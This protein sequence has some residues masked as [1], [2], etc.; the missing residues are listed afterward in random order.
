MSF[1]SVPRSARLFRP[2]A[3]ETP[4]PPQ[5]PTPVVHITPPQAR[6]SLDRTLIDTYHDFTPQKKALTGLEGLGSPGGAASP[7]GLVLTPPTPPRLRRLGSSS[8]AK[9]AS[10][11]SPGSLLARRAASGKLPPKALLSLQQMR[12]DSSAGGEGLGVGP[13]SAGFDGLEL[14][15]AL[16]SAG[17]GMTFRLALGLE[18]K[19]GK[20]S[21]ATSPGLAPD[22]VENAPASPLGSAPTLLRQKSWG[23]S[24][25]T[26]N[27]LPQTPDGIKFPT[28]LRASKSPSLTLNL[29]PPSL[30]APLSASPTRTSFLASSTSPTAG[31]APPSP[32]VM[33][34]SAFAYTNAGPLTPLTPSHIPGAPALGGDAGYFS[35]NAFSDPASPSCPVPPNLCQ[36]PETPTSEG[37]MGSTLS[38][39]R[40]GFFGQPETPP[41]QQYGGRQRPVMPASPLGQGRMLSQHNP[42][43]APA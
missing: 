4:T 11:D 31:S 17:A 20:V 32:L 23:R 25:G 16:S 1:R 24:G 42:F 8:S 43:F 26:V 5:S 36:A 38:P 15:P 21:G 35:W 9:T 27:R 41:A 29:S 33:R 19:D 14:S 3:D 6:L 28:A 2:L 34:S 30:G 22:D 10:P 40:T 12:L 13:G 37:K 39:L 7:G 18:G